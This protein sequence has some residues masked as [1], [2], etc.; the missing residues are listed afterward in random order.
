MHFSLPHFIAYSFIIHPFLSS[1]NYL[2]EDRQQALDQLRGRQAPISADEMPSS[3]DELRSGDE[4]PTNSRR[5]YMLPIAALLLGGAIGFLG[6]YN[7]GNDGKDKTPSAYVA[8]EDKSSDCNDKLANSIKENERCADQL[9]ICKT[10]DGSTYAAKVAKEVEEGDNEGLHL[11]LSD[12][13]AEKGHVSYE[14]TG[15]SGQ[16]CNKALVDFYG[17]IDTEDKFGHLKNKFIEM[18]RGYLCEDFRESSNSLIFG[19]CGN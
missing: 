15:N 4:E 18:T 19:K 8:C 10:A 12:H 9:E 3:A 6:G 13:L 5:G 14:L 11:V 2:E 16:K 17:S 7:I 1:S